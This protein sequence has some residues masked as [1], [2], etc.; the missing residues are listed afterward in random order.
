VTAVPAVDGDPLVTKVSK[1]KLCARLLESG[2]R[3]PDDLTVGRSGALPER[4]IQFGEGNFLRAF[5][6][7]MIERMNAQGL[8]GGRVVLVQP[9]AAGMAKALNAQ[10]GLYT[11]VLR[12]I[13]HGKVRET[14]EIVSSVSR[15]VD[16]Y[17]EYEA[18]LA[19]AANPDLRFVV[20]NTTEAGIRTDPADRVESRPAPSFPGKLTQ[21]LYA[22]FRHFAGDPRRGLVM[23][24]CELVEN[25]GQNLKRAVLETTE[26]WKL[27]GEFSRFL[28]EGCTFTNT[29]VDRIVTGYPKDEAGALAEKLGYEDPLLVAGEVFHAWVIESP[30]TLAEELPLWEAGLNVVFTHDITPYRE[31][32]VRILNGAHTMTALAAFLAGKETVRDVMQDP[33]FSSFVE[34]GIH[35]EILPT[36]KLPRP[37]L[38]GFAEAVVERFDNPFIRHNLISIALNSVSKYRA[39]I[40]G[41]VI[42]YTREKGTLPPR[43]TFALAALIVFYRGHE[44]QNGALIGERS[45][46]PY[47]ILDD[48]P[49][50]EFFRDAWA[51]GATV[52][53]TFCSELVRRVL[54]RT[55]FWGEDLSLALP[56]FGARVAEH[57][58]AICNIGVRPALERLG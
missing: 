35:D 3:F 15:C 46:A 22:R 58:H 6:D 25:N 4:V 7:W 24:P 31:R 51:G 8:F 29:L 28:N 2:H 47:R 50:L 12:G 32:K 52:D 19:C 49:V 5:V 23:L 33:L 37:E 1:P 27:P 48:A 18:F 41:T 42:D 13:E 40:L 17:T 30:P 10:Q 38:L 14:R 9:I 43:L 53:P 54:G 56:G 44:I 11:V 20:S 21:L 36:L 26:S 39:R 57:V 55:D 16:P 45:G 34:R